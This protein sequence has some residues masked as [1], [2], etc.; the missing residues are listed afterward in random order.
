MK[1]NNIILALIF[2][3]ALGLT[4]CN[5]LDEQAK[6]SFDPSYFSTDKGVEGGLTALYA[7]LR[8]LYGNGYVFSA[9]ETGTDEYT[10]GQSGNGENFTS[11]D[12]TGGAKMTSTNCDAGRWWDVFPTIN[13]ASGVIEYGEAGGM[14]A[15]KIAE[16]YF[17]RAFYYFHLVRNFG[18]V[19]LDLGNGEL[20][21]NNQAVRTSVRNTVAEVYTKCIFPDLLK[22]V[23]DLP[24][25]PRLTGTV[26][27]TVA[28][29]YL[30][31]AYLTYAWWLQNPN[32]VPTYPECDRTDPAKHDAAWYFQEAYNVAMEAINNPGPYKLMDTFYDVNVPTNDRNAEWLLWADHTDESDLYNGVGKNA[33]GNGAAPENFTSWFPCCNYTLMSIDGINPVQR[34]LIP[35]LGRPWTRNAPIIDVFTKLFTDEDIDSRFD[36]TFTYIYRANWQK[37][38]AS[39]TSYKQSVTGANGLPIKPGPWG[40][41]AADIEGNNYGLGDAVLTFLKEDVGGVDYSQNGAAVGGG[42]LPGRADF[43]IEPSKMTRQLYPVLWKIGPFRTDNGTGFGAGVNSGST[44]PMVIAKFSE[45]YFIAAEAAVKGATGA[46]SASDL[47][48]VIR[49]R[50]GKW[51]WDNN[52]G[53]KKVEDHSAEMVDKMP[54]TI[55]IDY[56]LDERSRELFGESMR[57]Y[58][59]T[60]TQT[61]DV[62]AKTYEMGG[63]SFTEHDKQTFTR[64]MTKG[65]YLRPIPQGQLDALEMTAEEKKAYQNPEYK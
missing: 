54:A 39:G 50:A 9:L 33:W 62:R 56:I 7:E 18:G 51:R 26:T 40:A 57:W 46:K 27:K 47:I 45:L 44:R 38:D 16:A 60:R 34:D 43:V 24:T 35:G 48:K 36:G 63:I 55:T 59:L 14:D 4:S 13:T 65:H 61:W 11:C 29:A 12:F 31:K 19:P 10:Y 20:A 22:A 49:E 37:A 42:V 6:S 58:D 30:A 41:Y 3:F 25:T 53:V 17:F 28:R 64:T 23:N 1:K 32:G 21:F 8:N 2:A 52:N 5:V 15:A